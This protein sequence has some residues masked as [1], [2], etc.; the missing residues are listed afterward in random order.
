MVHTLTPGFHKFGQREG[1]RQREWVPEWVSEW[2]CMWETDFEEEAEL[3]VRVQMYKCTART[4]WWPHHSTSCPNPHPLGVQLACILLVI[5]IHTCTLYKV[6]TGSTVVYVKP[7]QVCDIWVL[8]PCGWQRGTSCGVINY[9][10]PCV[11]EMFT[12]SKFGFLL[13]FFFFK[14]AMG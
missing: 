13:L 10:V 1:W 11:P 5:G 14:K 4:L 6:C 9:F 12:V 2:V 8:D 7:M 3:R